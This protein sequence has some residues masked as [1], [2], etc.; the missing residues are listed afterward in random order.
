MI[1][2]TPDS[3]LTLA[4]FMRAQVYASFAS[5]SLGMR[6]L[7]AQ[8]VGLDT[9][10]AHGGVFRTA[11]VAQRFLAAAIETP[12]AVS[13]TAGEGGAWG[14]AILAAYLVGKA[15]DEKFEDYLEK[16]VFAG[17]AG[18]TLA[19]EPA[20]EAGFARFMERYVAGLPAEKA[21]VESLK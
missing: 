16:K 18:Q 20:D 17:M 5:L 21:A 19:P 3:A 9:M 13:A 4:N 14:I 10:Y 6:T 8:A 15:P 11:D 7:T 2:R 1:V 12:V